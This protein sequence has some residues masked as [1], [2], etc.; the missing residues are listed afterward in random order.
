MQ[1]MSELA[2]Q[3]NDLAF[4][5]KTLALFND[6]KTQKIKGK[7]SLISYEAGGSGIAYLNYLKKADNFSDHVLAYA[8]KMVKNQ[9]RTSEGLMTAPWLKD[10]LDQIMIDCAFPVTPYLLY[11]G[12]AFNK[13]EYVDFAVFQT[14]EL[15]KILKDKNGLIHQGSLP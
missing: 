6:F 4:L 11:T 13:P 3:K 1:G 7:G 14:V 12:L 5:N 2:V 8:A 9:K 15:F 10:S